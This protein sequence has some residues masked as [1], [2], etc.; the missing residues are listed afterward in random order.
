MAAGRPVWPD[1][2]ADRRG[3]DRIRGGDR[4]DPAHVLGG[5]GGRPTP[6]RGGARRRGGGAGAAQ[7][8]GPLARA[9]GL[10]AAR[11][12]GL[13]RARVAVRCGKGTYVRTLAVVAGQ[14]ARRAGPPRRAPANRVRPLLDRP[15]HCRST[16]A[17][18]AGR[19]VP[20]AELVARIVPPGRRPARIPRRAGLG[21]RGAGAGAGEGARPAVRRAA[22]CRAID[23]AGD[24][25]AICA[26]TADGKALRPLRVFVTRPESQGQTR[27]MR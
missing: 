1:R 16:G 7:D 3:A 25:V 18:V 11:G 22:L 6:A 20:A 17:G 13:A 19:A 15:G 9:A 27:R 26:P 14:G 10:R 8:R 2:R 12:D 23:E 4:P 5:P 21:G 24:L